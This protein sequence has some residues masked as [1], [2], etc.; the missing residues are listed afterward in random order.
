MYLKTDFFLAVDDFD[1]VCTR[2]NLGRLWEMR[3]DMGKAKAMRERCGAE[4]MIC[5]NFN[6]GTPWQ[7]PRQEMMLT[8]YAVPAI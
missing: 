3:G 1:A 6:V 2:D 5:S 7:I 4:R 8:V